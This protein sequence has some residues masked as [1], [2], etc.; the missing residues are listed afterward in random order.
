MEDFVIGM[1]CFFGAAVAFALGLMM[2]KRRRVLRA[3]E[4]EKAA[5][6][7]CA[8]SDQVVAEQLALLRYIHQRWPEAIRVSLDSRQ[9]FTPELSALVHGGP[10]RWGLL[11]ELYRE[12]PGSVQVTLKSRQ[13]K[14]QICDAQR[15][16]M[17]VVVDYETGRTGSGR[18][19]PG[20]GPG[21]GGEHEA[22]VRGAERA[23]GVGARDA[24][25]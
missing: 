4:G 21:D 10:L 6:A 2:L 15:L 20:D 19:N 8:Q 3:W 22:G 18:R 24:G 9:R 23:D 25:V 17:R 7:A 11:E 16:G 1:L 14:M 5:I 12:R 13:H